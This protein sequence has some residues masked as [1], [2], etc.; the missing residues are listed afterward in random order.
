MMFFN[1]IEFNTASIELWKKLIRCSQY[2]E[3]LVL[4]EDMTRYVHKKLIFL[5]NWDISSPLNGIIRHLTNIAGGNVHDKGIVE[6]SWSTILNEEQFHGKF[7]CQLDDLTKY[8]HS[9]DS[10]NGWLQYDFK[11]RR[12]RPTHYAIRCRNNYDGI[13]LYPNEDSG[14]SPR[15][16]MIEVSNTGHENDWKKID[17]R[18]NDRS[19]SIRNTTEIFYVREKLEPNECFRFIRIRNHGKASDDRDFLIISAFEIYGDLYDL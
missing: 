18:K 13:K 7:A 2:H 1:S 17:E 11:E 19:F 16:W 6:V 14:S 15:D 10:P 3:N 8:Y 9:N 4:D 5:P 12:V